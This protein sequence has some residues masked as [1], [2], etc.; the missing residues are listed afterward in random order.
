MQLESIRYTMKLGCVSVTLLC[1]LGV[2]VANFGDRNGRIV[3]GSNAISNYPFMVSLRERRLGGE[4][5]EY[6]CSG[7][8]FNERWIVTAAHCVRD[9]TE[10]QITAHMGTTL[11]TDLGDSHDV[12]RIAIHPNYDWER[13]LNNIAM[14]KCAGEITSSSVTPLRIAGFVA[15]GT[16]ARVSGWGATRV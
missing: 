11:R 4:P 2:V 8:V 14:V 16:P 13:V 3:G 15:P 10:G 1:F 9:R 6:F 7:F 5:N 12:E